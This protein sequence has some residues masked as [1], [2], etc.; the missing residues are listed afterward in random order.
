M[1][2]ALTV[3]N[4]FIYLT[5]LY[6]N[7]FVKANLPEAAPAVGGRVVLVLLDRLAKVLSNPA[8]N[9]GMPPGLTKENS[10]GLLVDGCNPDKNSCKLRM[11]GWLNAGV[12]LFVASDESTVGFDCA[13]CDARVLGWKDADQ[14]EGNAYQLFEDTKLMILK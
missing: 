8:A 1:K 14:S 7:H 5:H 9:L 2:V 4:C 12:E 13:T 10:K 3:K 11:G 6:N